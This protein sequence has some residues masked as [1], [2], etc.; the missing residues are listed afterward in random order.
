MREI[1]SGIRRRRIEQRIQVSS[2]FVDGGPSRP[3]WRRD[4]NTLQ[5]TLTIEADCRTSKSAMNNA[6]EIATLLLV[7]M[8]SGSD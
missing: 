3:G 4:S 2:S 7:T 1:P 8:S 5:E 6:T